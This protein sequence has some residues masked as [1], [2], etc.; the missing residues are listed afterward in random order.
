[1]TKLRTLSA[2]Q[3]VFG[4][5]VLISFGSLQLQSDSSAFPAYRA[6][7][8]KQLRLVDERVKC[9]YC[10]VNAT[11]G[12]PWNPFGQQIQDAL[13]EN[14]GQTL[15]EVLKEKNDADSDGYF[16]AL[17]VFAGSLPGDKNTMPLVDAMTLQERFEKAGG[18][19]LFKPE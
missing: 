18:F 14:F 16:D 15:Y 9:T 5:T 13:T 6:M 8:V 3:Y 19:D 17:E 12:D 1:M 7:A 4:I 11:G 10:H 2:S